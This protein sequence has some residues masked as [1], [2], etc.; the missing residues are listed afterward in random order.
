[1]PSMT[2]ST[3]RATLFA[4]ACLAF[5]IFAMAALAQDNPDGAAGQRVTSK[6]DIESLLMDQTVYGRYV[7]GK[8]WE[9]YHSPDG[10][11]GYHQD[12]CTYL[13]HWWVADQLVCFRYDAFNQ[14]RPICFRLYRQGDK[15]SFYQP[16]LL[17]TW[18]LNAYSTDR[19]PGNPD[20][21]PIEGQACVG[22]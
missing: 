5:Q 9:E 13:G 11:T 7:T 8:A 18:L 21:L 16:G 2:R 17:G 1:M 20:K 10:R 22:V 14:G 3:F 15:L 12:G 4:M 6:A 19:K